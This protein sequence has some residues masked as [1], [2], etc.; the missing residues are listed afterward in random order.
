MLD[1][2][3]NLQGIALVRRS[4]VKGL[5]QNGSLVRVGE[6]AIPSDQSYFLM[7]SERAM[8]SRHG[9]T[10]IEWIRALVQDG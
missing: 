2:A 6:A 9:G 3:L 7:A 8:I 1:A 10:V 5:L 4:L